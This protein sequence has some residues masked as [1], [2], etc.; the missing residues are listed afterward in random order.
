[1]ALELVELMLWQ[2]VSKMVGST[3]VPLTAD[4]EAQLIIEVD[5]ITWTC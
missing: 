2:I 5:G 1:V 3:A 4:T